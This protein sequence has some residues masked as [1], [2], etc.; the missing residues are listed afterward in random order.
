M[1]G[2]YL[3]DINLKISKEMTPVYSCLNVMFFKFL[4][5]CETIFVRVCILMIYLVKLC[6]KRVTTW[7][8]ENFQQFFLF[9]ILGFMCKGTQSRIYADLLRFQSKVKN[10]I[11]IIILT[12]RRIQ[13][14]TH[15]FHILRLVYEQEKSRNNTQYNR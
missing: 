10:P 15:S 9:W 5:I 12:R 14:F 3:E 1:R 4:F 7:R 13:F 11:H 2:T 8:G 6:L